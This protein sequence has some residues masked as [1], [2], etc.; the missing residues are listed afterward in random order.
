MASPQPLSASVTPL[1]PPSPNTPLAVYA[2]LT[3]INATIIYVFMLVSVS[4]TASYMV[5]ISDDSLEN[6]AHVYQKKFVN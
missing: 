4:C 6:V 2:L 5:L 1:T 3:K